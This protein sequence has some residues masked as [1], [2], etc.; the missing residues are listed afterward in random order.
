APPGVAAARSPDPIGT[1]PDADLVLVAG[2]PRRR[3]PPQRARASR[4]RREADPD[5][6]P[7][8]AAERPSDVDPG[9]RSA[10]RHDQRPDRRLRSVR[11]DPV[12]ASATPATYAPAVTRNAACS[13]R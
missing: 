6:L 7:P 3:R 5:C 12:S 1:R 8:R 2:D 9:T 4:D 11:R 13:D 10:P